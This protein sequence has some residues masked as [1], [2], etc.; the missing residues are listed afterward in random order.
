MSGFV[1]KSAEANAKFRNALETAMMAAG[2][3]AVGMVRTQMEHGYGKP[4][5]TTGDL[6]KDIH[7]KIDVDS[8]TITV[9]TKME[10]ASY[11]HYGHA[12]HAVFFPD[13]GDKGGFLTMPG[14]YTPAKPFLTDALQN[15][16][17]VQRLK[18]ILEAYLQENMK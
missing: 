16:A 17:N 13:I 2:R 11:V 1:D 12:G 15:T 3:E 4:I 14:G 18:E 7:E 6:E 9:G 8:G 10:Y 5:H